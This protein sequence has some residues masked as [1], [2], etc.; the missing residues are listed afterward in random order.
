MQSRVTSRKEIKYWICAFLLFVI[1]YPKWFWNMSPYVMIWASYLLLIIAI[2][3][4]NPKRQ[5]IFCWIALLFQ[6][7]F[8]YVYYVLPDTNMNGRIMAL[9]QG[10]GFAS[11]F[12]CT[13]EFWKEVTDRFIKL[14]AVLLIPA[15][16][17]HVLVSYFSIPLHYYLIDECPINVGRGYFVFNFNVYTESAF[18][19]FNRFFSFYDEPG[20]LG[21]ILM[22]LLY[23]QKFNLKKWYNIVFLVAGILTYSL[24]FCFALMIYYIILSSVRT[25]IVF[26]L[27]VLIFTYL[28]YGNEY[29]D[30][31]VF[32][33]LIFEDGHMAGYNR[34]KYN[35]DNWFDSLSVKDYLFTGYSYREKIVYAASWKWAFALYGIIPFILFVFSIILSQAKKIQNR[36]GWLLGIVLVII[37][38]IQRPFIHLYLYSYLLVLPFIYLA[39]SSISNNRQN[40][41]Q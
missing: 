23:I 15:I 32:G 2:G 41:V 1:S 18:S 26:I 21:N 5:N 12:L 27:L 28:F 22:V 6:I 29:L 4:I 10:I 36:K 24:A 35:F 33:R 31:Y 30:Q 3:D 25:R 16:I 8:V 11:I 37:I 17:E 9:L 7:V 14:L 20:V 40:Y 34:E 39:Q 13:S 38:F 19:F